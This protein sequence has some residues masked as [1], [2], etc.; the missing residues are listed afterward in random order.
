MKQL[1]ILKII[2][3]FLKTNLSDVS[4]ILLH[5]KENNIKRSDRQVK[6]D[7]KDVAAFFLNEDDE[8]KITVASYKS[9]YESSVTFGMRK[10]VQAEEGIDDMSSRIKQLDKKKTILQNQ[11]N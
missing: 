1:E 7:L 5:L 6:R 3:T 2:Y 11:V 10:Q 8:M 9:L 4:M